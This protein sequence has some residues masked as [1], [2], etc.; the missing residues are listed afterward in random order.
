MSVLPQIL[1]TT[2]VARSR[3]FNIESVDL[4]FANGNEPEALEMAQWS[5]AD[6]CRLRAREEFSDARSLLATYLMAEKAGQR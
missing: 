2:I 3:L 6:L 4:R 5:L 1:K